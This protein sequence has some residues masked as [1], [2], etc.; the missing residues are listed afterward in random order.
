MFRLQDNS[1]I[2]QAHTQQRAIAMKFSTPI[3]F[4]LFCLL[5]CNLVLAEKLHKW[6]DANGVTHFS[7][8]P[9]LNQKSEI[10][11]PKTGHSDPVTYATA[12]AANSSAGSQ[13]ASKTASLNPER[14]TAARKN[15]ETLKTFT[16]I[17]IMGDNGEYRY[18]T[19]DEQKQQLKEAE[20][21]ISD[22]CGAGKNF[23]KPADTPASTSY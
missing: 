11:K 22:S 20:A 10:I 13:E 6:I 21:A 18:L 5:N 19:P 4:S 23:Q 3:V 17:K 8:H 16:R 15:Q 9:P 14:C 12:S 1:A 7:E 2:V